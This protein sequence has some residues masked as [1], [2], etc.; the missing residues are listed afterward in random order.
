MTE[1]FVLRPFVEFSRGG[2]VGIAAT[3]ARQG[4]ELVLGYTLTGDL[5]A[6]CLSDLAAAP[7]RQDQLWEGTCFEC[8]FAIAGERRYWEV[9]ISPAGHWNMYA[10]SD[11]RQGMRR[12]EAVRRLAVAS[13]RGPGEYRLTAGVELPD[14]LAAA[15]TLA[16]GLCA[17]LADDAGG[18]SYW[19]MAHPA[20]KPDFHHRG[21]FVVS[22]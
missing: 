1:T 2:A 7:T 8:F 18:C 21:G 17:V 5:A 11:Y 12:E 22:R 10:F 4:H 15:A 6:V 20:G 13:C 14:G 16:V 3:V 19:A 9:N